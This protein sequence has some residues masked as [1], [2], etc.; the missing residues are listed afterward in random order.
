MNL[1]PPSLFP[2]HTHTHFYLPSL[3]LPPAMSSSSTSL[4]AGSIASVTMLPFGAGG[5]AAATIPE[6]FP[7]LPNYTAIELAAHAYITA[8]DSALKQKA[9]VDLGSVQVALSGAQELLEKHPNITSYAS[10]INQFT[11]HVMV[12]QMAELKRFKEEH[13]RVVEERDRLKEENLALRKRPRAE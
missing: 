3:P 5:I 2:L 13:K 8:V 9:S 11:N 1:T 7:L 4:G 6:L 10:F 12:E